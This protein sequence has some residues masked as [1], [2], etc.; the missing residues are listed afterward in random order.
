MTDPPGGAADQRYMI[1]S[2]G[3]ISSEAGAYAALLLYIIDIFFK[4]RY[5]L[6][7]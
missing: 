2:S 4:N 1:N 5:I 3:S 7:K 6:V